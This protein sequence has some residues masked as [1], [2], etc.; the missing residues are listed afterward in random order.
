MRRLP[1]GALAVSLAVV[2]AA[3]SVE[4]QSTPQVID[5]SARELDVS[6]GSETEGADGATP[7]IR[8]ATVY[9]VDEDDLL[10]PVAR[11]VRSTPEQELTAVVRALVDGP[12]DDEADSGLRSAVPPA[13]TVLS[14]SLD[15]TTVTVDLSASFASIGGTAEL[16]A[17]GQLA[18]TATTF[19][20]ARAVR[21]RL[22][23]TPIDLPLPNGAL[24]D[25]AVTLRQFSALLDPL[26]PEPAN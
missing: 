14:A 4:P 17:V 20:G 21:L 16:L 24:T 12:T 6:I 22:D 26:A 5:L 18:V 7:T 10:V 13:T 11:E 8:T 3:C 25:Q 23:G 15:G 1:V 9:L 2:V 19:P